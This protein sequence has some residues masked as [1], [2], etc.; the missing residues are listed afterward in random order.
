MRLVLGAHTDFKY[1]KIVLEHFMQER[2]HRAIF[3]PKSHCEPNS[4]E[5]VW[6]EAK[7]YSRAHCDYSFTDIEQTIIP[8]L[9]FVHIDTIQKYFRKCREY[10]QAYR[11]GKSVGASVESAVHLYKS[12]R[13]VFGN[14]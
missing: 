13:R 12:H 11:E 10:M 8:A 4:I 6:R 14:V 1:E 5:R 2:G 9:E 7:I 3:L